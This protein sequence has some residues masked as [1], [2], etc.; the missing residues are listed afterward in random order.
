MVH[1]RK[2]V[3]E[4]AT[5]PQVIFLD[6]VG[7][8]F[9]VKSSV[10]TVYAEVAQQFGVEVSAAA[11]NQAFLQ[12]FR[13]AGS[14]AF[15][16]VDQAELQ[17]REFAWWLTIATNTFKQA[18]VW[19]QFSDFDEFFAALYAHFATAAPWVVY[20]DVKP[21]LERWQ[22]MGIPLGLLSNFDS[23]LY[24]VLESLALAPFF[25]SVTLSTQV[26]AAKP[27]PKIFSIA[28]QKH[29]CLPNAAWHI[30]DSFEEDYQAA[31]AVGMRGIWLRRNKGVG[32]GV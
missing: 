14:P 15:D 22:R 7:T 3:H 6:A 21:A 32:V 16:T 13:A 25:T 20:P 26:G 8:L 4:L 9:G 2:C 5:H 29:D 31:K 28:L 27:D 17:E 23:R 11:L 10:G 18:G 12:S 19:H 24:S 30:G 1:G